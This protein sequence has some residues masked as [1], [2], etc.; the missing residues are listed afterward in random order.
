MHSRF[1]K[2]CV[3]YTWLNMHYFGRALSKVIFLN[4]S[5]VMTFIATTGSSWPFM[6]SRCRRPAP[7]FL[8]MSR[9]LLAFSGKFQDP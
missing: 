7:G 5:I 1:V 6:Q 2:S 9:V 3:F 8:S 4:L